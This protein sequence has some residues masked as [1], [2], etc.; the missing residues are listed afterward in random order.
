[1]CG[2]EQ[3]RNASLGPP[4]KL[5]NLRVHHV[6]IQRMFIVRMLTEPVLV[7]IEG[8]GCPYNL[9]DYGLSDNTIKSS[10]SKVL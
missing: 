1:M 5:L 3:Q 6:D 9:F 4:I 10:L 7:E 2:E 8:I